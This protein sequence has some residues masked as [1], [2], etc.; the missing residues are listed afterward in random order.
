MHEVSHT[1]P[2]T[3]YV[4]VVVAEEDGRNESGAGG[5]QEE[6]KSCLASIFH[7]SPPRPIFWKEPSRE[8]AAALLTRATFTHT[9]LKDDAFGE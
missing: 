1:Y 8:E 6:E 4:L 5:G 3:T 9:Q 7:D 2:T